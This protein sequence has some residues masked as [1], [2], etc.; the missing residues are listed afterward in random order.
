MPTNHRRR[1]TTVQVRARDIDR[2]DARALLDIAYES[3]QLRP[4][5]HQA[6]VD[7]AAT[8]TTLAELDRLVNDLQVT[9]DVVGRTRF[10][11]PLDP[12]R[13]P[14]SPAPAP[15]KPAPRHR[16]AV[17]AGAALVGGLLLAALVA[18]APDSGTLLSSPDHPGSS[19]VLTTSG[20]GQMLD[21][22]EREFG[23]LLVDRIDIYPDR[24]V[25]E[26]PV[27]GKPGLDQNYR[28]EFTGST[29]KLTELGTSSRSSDEV[30]TDLTEL[31][32]N[33]PRVIGL[34]HGADRTLRVDNPTSVS[35]IVGSDGPV[36]EISLRNEEQGTAGS[37]TVGFDGD[38]RRIHRAD[39]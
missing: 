30:P 18:K 4:D 31:R 37:L 2:A 19:A 1:T 6:R 13:A 29:G 26:R 14:T 35:M 34:L 27:P 20:F 22:I 15:A 39:Q 33:L 12:P 5:E 25:I 24:T 7:S 10:T 16:T 36:A 3:G 38:I 9:D 21:D 23:D 11:P 17:V 32:Q 28:Y 8:A